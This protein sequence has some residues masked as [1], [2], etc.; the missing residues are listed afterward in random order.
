MREALSASKMADVLLKARPLMDMK[1]DLQTRGDRRPS[2]ASGFTLVEVVVAIAVAGVMLV[3][4]Y[5]G[6]ATGTFS[7][8]LARENLRATQVV[9]EKMEVIRLLTWDQIASS[10]VLPATFTVP[11]DP[12]GTNTTNGLLYSGQIKI[13]PFNPSTLAY[14]ADLKK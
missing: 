7:I 12:T 3:A 14:S 9:L 4:L 6:M 2:R 8:R 13:H 10:N 11:Y 1:I 5:A